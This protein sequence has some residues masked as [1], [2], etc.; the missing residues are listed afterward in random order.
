MDKLLG[1]GEQFMESQ[2]GNFNDN[3]QQSGG[4]NQSNQQAEQQQD[5]SQEN[6]GGSGGSGG[7]MKGVETQTEDAY[8][9]QA[10]DK[11]ASQE[12]VPTAMDGAINT[13]VDNEANQFSKNL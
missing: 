9:N 12:G 8:V 11:F 1:E 7:F 4:N 3:Q 6:Q 5:S 13:F 2:A 10:V